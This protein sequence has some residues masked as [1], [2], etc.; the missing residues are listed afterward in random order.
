MGVVLTSSQIRE[1][2][3]YTIENEPIKSIDL[4]ER[5]A[6]CC[7]NWIKNKFT[8]Q[9]V[10]AI[11]CGQ[12]NNGGDGLA[13]ARQLYENGFNVY[14]LLLKQKKRGTPDFEINLARLVSTGVSVTEISDSYDF[15][16]EHVIIDAINGTGLKKPLEG[17]LANV[18]HSINTSGATIISVDI[19]S[20]LFSEDT[21][22]HISV[23]NTV[24]ATYT[25]TFQAPK[26][27]FFLPDS[28]SY[29]GEFFI[30]D[31]GLD[32]TF[33]NKLQTSYYMLDKESFPSGLLK[34][35]KFSH[36]GN[37]G[38]SLLICGSRGKTGAAILTANACLRSGAGLVTVHLPEESLSSLHSALPEAMAIV[39]PNPYTITQFTDVSK[40]NAI[41]IG[42]GIGTSKET[43][44][45][46]KLLI[47]NV[48]IPLIIDAD[49]LNI[50]AEN[51]TWLSFLPA[52]SILTPHPGEFDRLFGKTQSHKQRLELQKEMSFKYNVIIVLKVAHTSVSLPDGKIY[53]NSSGNPGMATAGSGDV[54]TGIITGLFSQTGSSSLSSLLGVYLHG[55]AGDFAADKYGQHSMIASDIILHLSEAFNIID[56]GMNAH[57]LIF[58]K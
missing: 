26:L 53:F 35:E 37:Y 43:S 5:A 54:L 4:M 57:K 24:K 6:L 8:Q 13:I 9:T 29:V 27:S 19:P 2:D 42:P 16:K 17:A 23:K 46:L 11:I 30:L 56:E 39:D 22:S 25:L 12:G 40:F 36:K 38:H 44:S 32:K 55:V 3:A 15:K 14:V 41:G 58:S 34:R 31:I 20:G 45:F 49:A 1:A 18:V 50:L 48:N 10:F 7:T 33:I 51:K 47:Q 21:N 52:H 28:G